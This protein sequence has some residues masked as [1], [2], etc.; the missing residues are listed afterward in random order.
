MIIIFVEFIDLLIDYPINCAS[1]SR[2]VRK[3]YTRFSRAMIFDSE[4]TN[5]MWSDVKKKKKKNINFFMYNQQKYSQA[6]K[7]VCQAKT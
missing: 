3:K 2:K 6:C 7:P 5:F 4:K 1:L